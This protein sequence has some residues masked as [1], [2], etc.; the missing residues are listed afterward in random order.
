MGA[1]PTLT[2]ALVA[3]SGN[4]VILIAVAILGVGAYYL[5]QSCAVRRYMQRPDDGLR[6]PW[7]HSFVPDDPTAVEG[8]DTCT[9]CGR[10][11]HH[12]E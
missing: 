4:E 7:R 5:I 1:V 8:D 2:A 6:R 12:G 3:V 10:R 9:R 11:R